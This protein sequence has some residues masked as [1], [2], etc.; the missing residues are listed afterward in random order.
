MPRT[1]RPT[2][3]HP[4]VSAARMRAMAADDT[5]PPA[6]PAPLVPMAP[7]RRSVSLWAIAALVCA[8]GSLCP[9]A[10]LLGLVLGTV[11]MFDVRRPNRSGK[12]YAVAAL[13]VSVLALGG[14]AL[15]AGWWNTH[16]RR[17][18]LYGPV[19]AIAAGQRGEDASAYS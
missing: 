10:P 14:W 6:P 12:R 4:P 13:I 17:P 2:H 9:I 19:N 5:A 18:M 11:A 15:A 8:I 16:A 7:A 3:R 1:R